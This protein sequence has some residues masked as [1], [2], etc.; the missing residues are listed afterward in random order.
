[1]NWA[2]TRCVARIRKALGDGRDGVVCIQTVRQRGYRFLAPVTVE[3][4]SAVVPAPLVPAPARPARWRPYFVGREAALAQ[5]TQCYTTACQGTRQ[6]VVVTGELGIGKTAV[7]QAWLTQVASGDTVWVAHGQ[8]SE[9][10]GP[11]EPYRP[12]L[13]A[14]G[15]LGRAPEARPL[16]TVLRQYAP[17]WLVHL[18]AL[19]PPRSGRR[20]SGR[21]GPWVSRRCYVS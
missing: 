17:H 3:P 6:C 2:L 5:L 4:P 10:W 13:E 14:L 1:M 15:R 11:A 20:S 8:C 18:P 19:L 9:P 7:L 16:V 21:W 12:L